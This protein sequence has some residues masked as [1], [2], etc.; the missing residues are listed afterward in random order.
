M[1]RS[2]CGENHC[3]KG[4]RILAGIHQVGKGLFRVSIPSKTLGESEPGGQ[5]VYNGSN[6]IVMFHA[7]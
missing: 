5:A 4:G 6:D 2:E 3:E 7:V 1:K